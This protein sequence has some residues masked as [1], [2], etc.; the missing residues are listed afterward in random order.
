MESGVIQVEW[1]DS[2]PL[3]RKLVCLPTAVT[4]AVRMQKATRTKAA[5]VDELLLLIPRQGEAIFQALNTR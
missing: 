4:T 1:P 5:L 3:R 2:E